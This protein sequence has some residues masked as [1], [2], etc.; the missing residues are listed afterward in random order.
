MVTHSKRH[1]VLSMHMCLCA[2]PVGDIVEIDAHTETHGEKEFL[3][4]HAYVLVIGTRETCPSL[5]MKA[6]F[7]PFISLIPHIIRLITWV[8][9][10]KIVWVCSREK[11]L[12]FRLDQLT[13][14]KR[15]RGK[16]LSTILLITCHV[17]GIV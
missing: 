7:R 15:W 8:D 9:C 12:W 13:K 2:C 1:T 10:Y 16:A 3:Y 5:K 17:S 6:S 4:M 14:Y 11:S